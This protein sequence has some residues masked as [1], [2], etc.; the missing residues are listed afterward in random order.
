MENRE[1]M[2]TMP[3]WNAAAKHQLLNPRIFVTVPP[4]PLSAALYLPSSTR[5][6]HGTISGNAHSS[7]SRAMKRRKFMLEC[8]RIHT[9][10]CE[11]LAQI[12]AS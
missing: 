3:I 9:S 4:V 10:E 2:K 5:L 12:N 6:S 8:Q 1:V 7:V 11:N